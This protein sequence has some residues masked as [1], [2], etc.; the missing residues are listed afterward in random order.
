MKTHPKPSTA[1]PGDAALWRLG[2]V[3]IM[4][5]VLSILD[6]TIVS[7]GIGTIAHDLGSPLTTVQWVSSAYLLAA[8]LT[9]PL[10][11]WLTDRFGGKAVWLG[12]VTLFTAGTLLC[13]FAWS[14]PALI[15]FRTLHGLGGG[16][17]QP[18]G[19]ALFA[20]SAGPKLARMIGV[21]TL[22]ATVAPVLGPLLGGALIQGFGWR[23]LFFGVVPLGLATLALGSRILPG[24]APRIE[25]SQPA[26]A[27]T[28]PAHR[29]APV[30]NRTPS[31]VPPIA[32]PDYDTSSTE[33]H[34]PPNPPVDNGTPSTAP[35]EPSSPSADNNSASTAPREPLDVR[36]LFLLP[37]GLA[38]LG[39]GLA[40]GATPFAIAG[41][42]LLVAYGLH[43]RRAAAPL[44]DLNLFS[45]KPFA[46]ASASTF[47]LGASL[48][49]SMLLLPLYYEQ[50]EHATAL[51][52]GLLL[53]PQALGSATA[54]LAGG[55]I[56]EKLGP[57]TTMLTGI[58]LS[59]LGTIAFTQLDH[60]P[61]PALLT[62]SLFIRGLGLG[63][64][65]T[66][67]MTMLY[68]SLPRRK[69]PRAAAAINVVNRIGG[70]LGTALLVAVLHANSFAVA[71]TWALGLSA[72]GLVPAALFP[73]GP[74]K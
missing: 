56:L 3:L 64:T 70:S 54:L 20:R 65:T 17:M 35:P 25:P 28:S 39:Y 9:I 29:P 48:Y 44:L 14:A 23:W 32:R 69:I 57:R 18:V 42:V 53:A 59:L 43:A 21:V 26:F 6:A 68:T 34:E 36:G 62:A 46:L 40:A 63:A 19:Q 27:T 58:G 61:S 52:A 45:H 7:V 38:A 31:T 13:G 60:A 33:P 50:A 72:L 16:L 10:S 8:S 67:G 11:G 71:F 74:G 15:L 41:A 51:T 2:G 22:P 47:L 12:A 66:P 73:K 1:D 24:R 30:D 37:P 5:A 49:S 55:K 4:G